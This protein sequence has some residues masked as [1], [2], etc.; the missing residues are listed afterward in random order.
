MK[1]FL[2]LMAVTLTLGLTTR[3]ADGDEFTVDN[4]K[5][6]VLSEEG[7]SASLV[8]YDVAPTGDLIIS[9]IVKTESSGYIVT[10]IGEQAFYKCSN[11]TSVTIP[12]SVTAIGEKAFNWCSNLTSV[13]LP[14]SVTEIAYG[15][16][17]DCRGLTSVTIPNSVTKIGDYAFTRLLQPPGIR[18]HPQLGD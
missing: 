1:K 2:L 17:I 15:T 14:N 4:L 18:Y 13:T 10:A 5:Y 6:K 7:K 9:Q 12:N 16:F 3:A 8:G 11:L